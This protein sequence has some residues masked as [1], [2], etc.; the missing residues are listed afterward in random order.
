M[1][2]GE[3]ERQE[4]FSE[5]PFD[6][7][8]G[9]IIIKATISSKEFDFIFDT[10]APNVISKELAQ[11]LNIKP[12]VSVK[13]SDSQGIKE[14]LDYVLLPKV[15]VGCVDFL[16]TGAAV[17]DLKRSSVIGCLNVDGIIGANL[18]QK[19][20][21]QIDYKN[22]LIIVSNTMD[23]FEIENGERIPF[24]QKVTG[25][26]VTD[27]NVNGTLVKNVTIDTG[28]NG[29]F[30][31]S[32]KTYR[33][34]KD[35]LTPVAIGVGTTTSGIYGIGEVDTNYY[36][37]FPFVSIGK[38]KLENQLVDFNKGKSLTLGNS[39]FENYVTTYNWPEKEMI[40]TDN[41][42]H[43]NSSFD[44]FGFSYFFNDGKLLVS[45]LIEDSEADLKGIKRGDQ[46]LSLNGID[47]SE[48]NQEKWCE[49]LHTNELRKGQSIDITL[50]RNGEKTSFQFDKKNQL[51]R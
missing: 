14:E 2:K 15:T 42:E 20:I 23:S 22:K 51:F 49:I 13:T 38:L 26:P 45:L 39:F 32:V 12:Y 11:E 5:I 4:F 16:N 6:D 8:M 44:S 46:I 37:T 10:G 48:M 35:S 28:S 24:S 36:T 43:D 3:I 25:T 33:E 19:A 29:G 9:L 1:S 18:M 30:S 40:L 41:Q 50:L 34:A 7:E 17:A 27:I 31:L 21:W 47:Y